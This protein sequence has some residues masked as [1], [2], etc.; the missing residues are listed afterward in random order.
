MICEYILITFLNKPELFFVHS[1]ETGFNP[2]DL[3][4][5]MD[6]REGWRERVR[7]IRAD[8]AT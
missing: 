8:S 1:A 6:D 2:E 7:N 4:K 5:A 3:L